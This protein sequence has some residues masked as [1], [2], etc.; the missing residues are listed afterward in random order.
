MKLTL[1]VYQSDHLMKSNSLGLTENLGLGFVFEN[2]QPFPCLRR[3]E[4]DSN[5]RLAQNTNW[6]NFSD[7]QI[8]GFDIQAVINFYYFQIG[9][10][11]KW[12]HGLGGGGQG[13]CDD[14]T[15]AF[16]ITCVTMVEGDHKL[17]KIRWRH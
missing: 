2:S 5:L 17:S 6:N 14:I 9:V 12:R 1:E 13:Y 8:L 3:W 10:L 4:L 7:K 11:Y 15:K 16:V